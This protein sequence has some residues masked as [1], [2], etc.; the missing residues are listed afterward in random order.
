MK[1]PSLV[2]AFLLLGGVVIARPA[3]PACS[4]VWPYTAT[5]KVVS[6]PV[7]IVT[8]VL[9][10]SIAQNA[11]IRAGDLIVSSNGHGIRD[12]VAF[13]DFL[14]IMREHA[15]WGEARL[16]LLRPLDHWRDTAVL[17]LATPDDRMGFASTY[18]FYVEKVVPGGVGN[19]MGLKEGDF[20][21]KI[22]GIPIG[23]L[24]G[25]I[26]FDVQIQN[27]LS[28]GK[29]TL[30]ISRLKGVSGGTVT[31]VETEISMDGSGPIDGPVPPPGMHCPEV[32]R[33]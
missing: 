11:G 1:I 32:N 5:L 22:N 3:S 17:R 31:W 9:P 27:S 13:D 23:N 25:P 26:D 33:Y 15:L 30:G 24:R 8:D 4:A 10:G 29:L 20:L 12:R 14:A 28:K 2:L 7:V 6:S 18:G 16:E 21:S 19:K